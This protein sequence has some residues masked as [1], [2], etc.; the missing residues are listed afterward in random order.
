[1]ALKAV[2]SS[3]EGLDDVT[4]AFYKEADGKYVL[5]LEGVDEMPA[6]AAQRTKTRELLDE[7]KK[8]QERIEALGVSTPEEVEELKKAAKSNNS[9]RV[10]EL[11]AKLAGASEASQKEILAAKQEAEAERNAARTFFE[12]AE[13]TRALTAAKGVPQLLSHVVKSHLKTDRTDDGKFAMKVLGRDGQP[14]I[15]DGQGNPFTIDDLIGELKQDPMYGR[16]FEAEGKTGS[17]ATGGSGGGGSGK[18]IS[19]DDPIAFGQN[20]E[21]IAKG[22]VTV[23]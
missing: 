22:E 6:F 12:E 16:A 2:L 4:K 3:I 15:K 8:L 13:I 21:A 11:E 5:D 7:K 20:L 17:G 18:V 19:K 1:M 23:Q 9:D 14:R 10:K